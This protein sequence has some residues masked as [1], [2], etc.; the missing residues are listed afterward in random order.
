M[1][2]FHRSKS[3]G[4][5][6]CQ[7]K[8]RTEE[9]RNPYRGMYSILRFFAESGLIKDENLP[10]EEAVLSDDETLVLIEINLQ[11]FNSGALSDN[12][13]GNIDHILTVFSQR[14][15]GII[16]R[17]LYDWDGL[18]AQAE[19]DDIEIILLHMEQLKCLFQ[20]YENSIYIVQG[21]FIGSWGEMHNTR[22]HAEKDIRTLSEKLSSVVS[23]KTFLA[24]RCPNIWRT[25]F[26]TYHPISG[27]EAVYSDSRRK[28]SLYN[29]AIM[30]SYTD[31][32]TY[33]EVA[34]SMAVRWDEKFLRWDEIEFQNTLCQFVPNGGEVVNVSALNDLDNAVTT[35]REMHVSYINSQYDPRVIE[36]WKQ[37]IVK[38]ASLI[39]N[40]HTGYEYVSAHLG[41]RFLV[42][43]IKANMDQCDLT[44]AISVENS[45]FSVCYRD[46]KMSLIFREIGGSDCQRFA[47]PV[48][49]K[50][51][52]P[53]KTAIVNATV[54]LACL[55][56][57]R[58]AVGIDLS[59]ALTSQAVQFA[60]TLTDTGLPNPIGEILL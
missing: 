32:G 24:V 8:E 56:G 13:L 9:L 51:W 29:D 60:N 27:E 47:V 48:K 26:R 2:W 28:F 6:D 44:L 36:K 16:L 52:L 17:F 31:L 18:G 45:G 23:E 10:A 14:K 40:G 37:S 49:T 58:Y 3:L 7:L 34:Q 38:R 12:A 39:W 59:C 46:L 43:K 42:R 50:N 57:S 15:K 11:H 35:L 53:G 19:P 54:P 41:Y 4:W 21:L 22:Y 30:G 25:I 33:G 1:F 5:K 55:Q 20:K